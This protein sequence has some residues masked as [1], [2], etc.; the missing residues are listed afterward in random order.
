FLLQRLKQI[1]LCNKLRVRYVT[2]MSATGQKR[3]SMI[4]ANESASPAIVDLNGTCRQSLMAQQGTFR[5]PPAPCF[6]RVTG[7]GWNE[8][9]GSCYHLVIVDL[10]RRLGG[11]RQPMECTIRPAREDDADEI[12]AV[13]LHTLRETNSKDYA[14][15]I[16]ERIEHGFSPSAVL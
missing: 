10:V 16:I 3:R 1:R 6:M 13:I 14:R 4:V 9:A 12:G 15:E 11:R 5:S 7:Q 2:R 8:D